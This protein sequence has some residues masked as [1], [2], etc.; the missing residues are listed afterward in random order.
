MITII[1]MSSLP[2]DLRNKIPISIR[3]F[4]NTYE[5]SELPVDIRRLVEGYYG[6]TSEVKYKH[7]Y[8]FTPE[9]TEYGDF[10]PIESIQ[11]LVI[12]YLQNYLMILP[13]QYPFD[14]EF[15][16]NLKKYILKKDTT[17]NSELLSG[18]VE[19]LISNIARDIDV[20]IDVLEFNLYKNNEDLNIGM[21]YYF[22]IKLD[23]EGV[24]K[25]IKIAM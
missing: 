20:A 2:R 21:V 16:C 3:A 15:G 9:L 6:E 25:E 1:D 14:A 22:Y 23:I 24:I 13:N 10:K 8:D 5:L 18:E 7:V 12:E 4:K 17:L 19:L 11:D